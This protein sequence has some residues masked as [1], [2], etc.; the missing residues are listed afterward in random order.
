CKYECSQCQRSFTD[1]SSLLCH[2]RSQHEKRYNIQCEICLKRFYHRA[3]YNEHMRVHTGE[4]PYMCELCGKKFSW[5]DSVKKHMQ[6]HSAESKYKCR[7]CGKWFRWLQ[8]V[9]Q[10]LQQQHKLKKCDIEAQVVTAATET[11]TVIS[12]YHHQPPPPPPQPPPPPPL[13]VQHQHQHPPQNLSQPS[14]VLTQPHTQDETPSG[15]EYHTFEPAAPNGDNTTQQ[16]LN[17]FHVPDVEGQQQ[18]IFQYN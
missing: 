17:I 15:T 16:T 12:Q 18:G 3:H 4:K 11:A 5:H 8:G 1:K 10:H 7:L 14:Q 9:R 13:H 2:I 6:T